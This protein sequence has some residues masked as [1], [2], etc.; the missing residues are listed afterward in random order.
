MSMKEKQFEIV[1]RRWNH[2]SGIEMMDKNTTGVF[3]DYRLIYKLSF[4]NIL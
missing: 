3:F 1:S 4:V 2:H